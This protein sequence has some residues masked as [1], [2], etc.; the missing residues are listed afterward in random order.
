MPTHQTSRALLL[1]FPLTLFS[2]LFHLGCGDDSRSTGSQVKFSE[3]AKAQIN[4]MRDMYKANK[5]ATKKK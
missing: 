4:D 1:L 2:P 3:E 5:A